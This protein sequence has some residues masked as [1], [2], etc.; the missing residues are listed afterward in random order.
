[1][2]T[3]LMNE[4]QIKKH[5]E[6]KTNK[7][8]IEDNCKADY[9]KNVIENKKKLIPRY[10]EIK[11]LKRE[12]R[13][14]AKRRFISNILLLIVVIMTGITTLV[15]IAGGIDYRKTILTIV[16]FILFVSF[17]QLTILIVSCLKPYLAKKAPKYINV[18][19]F[20]QMCL[21]FVSI[22]FNFIFMYN[23][24]NS[25]FIHS[26]NVVLCIIFDVVIILLCEISFT[27]R[28]NLTF[29]KNESISIFSRISNI[30]S[31]MINNKLTKIEDKVNNNQMFV[32]DKDSI[33]ELSYNNVPHSEN[34]NN[35]SPFVKD[36][37]E[38]INIVNML[39]TTTTTNETFVN[40]KDIELIKRAI[41]NY[42]DGN[43][44]PSINALIDLTGLSK[45]KVIDIKKKLESMGFI[46]TKGLKTYIVNMETI[47]K[48]RVNDG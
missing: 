4:E 2:F 30:F 37:D 17:A 24:Q 26:L 9:K 46:R 23:P 16:T 34:N 28:L 48:W 14:P 31:S 29:E 43:I 11:D 25:L 1:M 42:R 33:K 18:S 22:S 20:C 35:P 6:K 19:L 44:C 41:L 38:N 39:N 13:E 40:D 15:T 47:D 5:Y 10:Q 32:N 7:K 8:I 12:M 36:K 27:I 45:S 21:L 3:F